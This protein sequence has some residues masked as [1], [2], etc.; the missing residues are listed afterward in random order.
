MYRVCNF[1]TAPQVL[2]RINKYFILIFSI[3]E[4]KLELIQNGPS[5]F[6]NRLMILKYWELDFVID[7][8]SIYSASYEF[9]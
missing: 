1:V 5:T 3:E 9:N 7:V 8:L 6:N 4:D 2:L